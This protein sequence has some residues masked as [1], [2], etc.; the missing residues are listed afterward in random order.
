MLAAAL[1]WFSRQA[2]SGAWIEVVHA[3]VAWILPLSAHAQSVISC[4]RHSTTALQP[5]AT[6]APGGSFFAIVSGMRNKIIAACS[7]IIA[8]LRPRVDREDKRTIRALSEAL[9]ESAER[10][11]RQQERWAE[12]VAEFCEAR[13]MA[14]MGPWQG[15]DARARE[16]ESVVRRVALG[17]SI[18][19]PPLAAGA[20]GDIELALQNVQ[21]RR[22]INLSWLEFS[23]WGIQQIILIARL[24]YIKN[25]IIQRL[26]NVCAA[27]VFARGVDIS[28]PDPA[29]N[30]EIQRFLERNKKVLGQNALV[31]QE[32]RKDYD[33]NLF[34]VLFVNPGSGEVDVRT[35]DATEMQDIVCNPDDADE[36]WYYR[37]TWTER[38]FDLTSGAVTTGSREAWY[39]AMGYEPAERPLM[40]G[41]VPVL[42]DSPVYHRK[43]GAV[44][45]WHFGCPRIYAAIDW[46]RTV[47]DFLSNCATINESLAQFSMKLTTKGGQQ[48]MAAAKQQLATTVGPGGG[49]SLWDTN[50]PA[51]TGAIF[52][53]GP[54][55][56]LEPFRT[57][58]AGSDPEEC[59]QYKLMCCNVKGVPETFLSDVSTGNLATATSLDRPTETTMLEYQ[60]A[61]CEDLTEL[62]VYALRMSGR[63]ANGRLRESL[64]GKT[65]EIRAAAWVRRGPNDR[66]V[67]EARKYEDRSA[68]EVQVV[69]PAI[70]E[71]DIPQLIN[72]TAEAMTLG[73]KS[74]SVIGIDEKA[75]VLK[76]MQLLGV[77]HA[78]EIVE[79]MYPESTYDPDRT[80]E[81]E[82]Q[83]NTVPVPGGPVPGLERALRRL[84]TAV[85]VYQASVED[86]RANGDHAAHATHTHA[87]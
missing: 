9:N 82:P 10:E 38:K 64:A 57:R 56:E 51:V 79:R 18:S 71:G 14:G 40:I 74:G 7:R 52:A 15:S 45:K 28:S 86:E 76:L 84:G 11:Q 85:K 42:W 49:A 5:P 20:Y 83:P 27:Y 81:P 26:I 33:G 8:G 54:G 72:A 39:P 31:D 43:C 46:A 30:E 44:A 17:E 70:R 35:I 32:R 53:S 1:F 13:Q 50:P 67:M 63:A 37:R 6:S 41:N 61:W 65:A 80:A 77:E 48:A 36:P 62:C 55:T 19:T 4:S 73:N 59:R 78:P 24:F 69:F 12:R 34:W 47:K 87:R 16:A 3:L 2:D 22:E 23:R 60:E 75:G 68:I 21:W 29:A 25:P 66:R 58:G